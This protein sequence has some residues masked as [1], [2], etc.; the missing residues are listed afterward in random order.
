MSKHAAL[1][2][3]EAAKQLEKAAHHHREAAVHYEVGELDEA[4]RHA[5]LASN[6]M[7]RA[8]EH[9]AEAATAEVE[10]DRSA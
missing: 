1:Q 3:H 5:M 6:H 10:E 2:H 4:N 9:V 8:D 7:N